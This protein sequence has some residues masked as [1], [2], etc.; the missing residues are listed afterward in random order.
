MT[1]WLRTAIELRRAGRPAVLVTVAGVRGSAPREVGAK[2]LVTATD[3]IGTIGGGELEYQCTQIAARLL[4]DGGEGGLRR[5]PL[6]SNCGQC[7]G[8]VVDALF[9]PLD[10]FGVLDALHGERQ[11][12]RPAV[13]LCW[14]DDGRPRRALLTADGTLV[15]TGIPAELLA[16]GRERLGGRGS[17]RL[18]TPGRGGQF[19]L[20]EALAEPDF[21]V[22]VFGAGHVGSE[23]VRLL[24]GLDCTVRWIDARRDVFPPALPDNVQ[25]VAS[26]SPAR[27]VAALPPGSHCLVMT[28]S[29]AQDL[30]I[31][32]ALLARGDT[33]YCGLIGSVTKR[34]RFEARLRGQGVGDDALARLVCPIGVAGIS[35][36]RP[37]EIAIAVTA[38]LLQHRDSA[39]A[40]NDGQGLRLV[41]TQ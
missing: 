16:A 5:F 25:P 27:E 38:E 41:S 15:G 28:H 37:A 4:A 18:D 29:H 8:G 10:G 19:A 14:L 40:R 39:A 3:S 6:G 24:A 31:V 11:A 12:R 30:D 1:D 36:K 22:A 21:H 35:G 26:D 9:E 33:A 23:V 34:R 20:I 2:M 32:A 7:C 13:Q 17:Q